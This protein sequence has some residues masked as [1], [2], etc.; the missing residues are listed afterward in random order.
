MENV[1]PI[2]TSCGAFTSC[3]IRET[4]LEATNIIYINNYLW[5]S[6]VDPNHVKQRF[7]IEGASIHAFTTSGIKLLVMPW[8]ACGSAREELHQSGMAFSQYT[9]VKEFKNT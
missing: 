9:F 6:I 8:G 4:S 7:A 2:S 3:H 5:Q 1:L